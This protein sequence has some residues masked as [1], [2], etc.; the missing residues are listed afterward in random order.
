MT[1]DREPDA[2]RANLRARQLQDLHNRSFTLVL[3]AIIVNVL[4]WGSLGLASELGT[5]AIVPFLGLGLAAAFLMYQ[6]MSAACAAKGQAPGWAAASMAL[7]FIGGGILGLL[8]VALLPDRNKALRASVA[9]GRQLYRPAL[10]SIIIGLPMPYLGLPIAIHARI[11]IRS[12]ESRWR[13]RCGLAAGIV[14]S[15]AVLLVLG[16]YFLG[17]RR[18]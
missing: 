2:E 14:T 17:S 13:G 4:A 12:D 5:L 3:I 18:R 15:A 7:T 10:Y 16:L 6:G 11:K 1:T 8:I 9:S